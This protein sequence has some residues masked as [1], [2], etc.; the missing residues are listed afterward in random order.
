MG[1]TIDADWWEF[2]KRI[3]PDYVISTM[4]ISD[5][6]N[7][8]IKA[9]IHPI[10]IEFAEAESATRREAEDFHIQRY[11]SD[12]SRFAYAPKDVTDSFSFTTV[13][14]TRQFSA[15]LDI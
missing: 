4:A 7:D 15:W 8:R 12:H 3:D 2:L 13:P 11:D 5:V 6:L 14:D 10:D 9:E 1:E